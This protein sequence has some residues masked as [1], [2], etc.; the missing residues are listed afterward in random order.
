V[1]DLTYVRTAEGFLFLSLIT[2]R[3]SRKIVGHQTEETLATKETVKALA[4]A[5]RELPEGIHPIHHSDRG[6]Q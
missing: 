2:D 5:L 3:Y 6:S 1:S 4:Q